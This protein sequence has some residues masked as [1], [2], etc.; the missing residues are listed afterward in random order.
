[1]M[2][3]GKVVITTILYN[4]PSNSRILVLAYDLLEDRRTDDDSARFKFF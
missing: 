4:N 2:Q 1:M 3:L